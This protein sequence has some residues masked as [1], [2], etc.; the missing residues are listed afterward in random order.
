MKRLAI[1]LGLAAGG[2]V[3]AVLLFEIV[4]RVIGFNAPVWYRPDPQLGASLRPRA[5]GWF[6]NEGRAYV[7]VNSA[8][9]RDREHAIEKPE[10]VYRIAV[11]G[12]SYAEAMQVDIEDT[13]WSLLQ[14]KLMR[15]AYQPG[16][17]V[18]TINFGVS[19]FGTAQQYLMLRSMA[20]HYRP[21]L[22]LLQ[23]TS[24]NDIRNNSIALEPEKSRP[25][26]LLD[27]RGEVALDA[28]FAATPEF[29]RRASAPLELARS[30]SDYSRVLQ[31]LHAARN[32]E[33]FP[34]ASAVDAGVEAGLDGAVLVPPRDPSWEEAWAVTERLM[35]RMSDYAQ[36]NGSRFVVVTVP[37]AIQV[38][39]D[40]QVREALQTRLG[41]SD[42]FYPDRRIEAF[43][44]GQGITAIALAYEMQHLAESGR[45]HFHGFENTRMG[46]GHWNPRGHRAAA[47]IIA[48]HLCA[49]R[50]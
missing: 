15:C 33:L 7:R 36:R 48:R 8:G 16:K 40:R 28:S 31:L 11:L 29:R 42:L 26:F 46:L 37:F 18:E 49:E 17:R 41:V 24:G 50:R 47:D 13:F 30:L 19:G 6:T 32:V 34:R 3:A 43:A 9:L 25:F 45:V 2:A 39:P 5:E 14:E 12:D 44:R 27:K 23:F 22:V 38:H 35:A 4:L 20:I 10:G 1:S 21:D